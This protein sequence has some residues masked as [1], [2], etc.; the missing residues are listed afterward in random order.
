MIEISNSKTQFNGVNPEMLFNR[1]SF[2]HLDKDVFVLRYELT[3][4]SKERMT[5]FLRKENEGLTGKEE[6]I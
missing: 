5:E 2:T 6:E 1:L 4:P 3:I